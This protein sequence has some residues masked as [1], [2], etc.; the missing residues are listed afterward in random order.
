AVAFSKLGLSP[1]GGI[2]F[3][4]FCLTGSLVNIPV[5]RSEMEQYEKADDITDFFSRFFGIRMPVVH[6]RIIA[7]NLGGAI[8]PGLLCIYLLTKVSLSSAIT[9]TA[10]TTIFSYFLSKPVKGVGIVIPAFIPPIIAAVAALFFA[11]RESAPAVAYISG[12]L[13]TLIGADLLRLHQIKKYGLSFLSIGGA[14]VFDG[15]FIVG[16]IAVLLA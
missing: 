1:F 6:E 7:L 16:I 12:V 2:A 5:S 15:I 14:G 4:F 13:G 11:E 9:A 3:Y 8:L 10:V